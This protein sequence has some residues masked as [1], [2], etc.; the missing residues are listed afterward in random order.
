MNN[1]TYTWI[2]VSLVLIAIL[3][4]SVFT[5]AAQ[6]PFGEKPTPIPPQE[7]TPAPT[8]GPA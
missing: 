7:L 6:E 4:F 3:A 8:R 5:E 2:A 1:K